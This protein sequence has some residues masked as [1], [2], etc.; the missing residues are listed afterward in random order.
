MRLLAPA[1][2]AIRSTRAPAS[3]WVANSCFAAS[4][5][6]S[7]MPSGS[8]CHFCIRLVLIKT[9]VRSFRKTHVARKAGFENEAV[10]P[11][12][13]EASNY[14]VQLHIGEARDSGSG[15]LDHPGMTKLDSFPGQR[16]KKERHSRTVRSS[17]SVW[18]PQ[19]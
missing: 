10:I 15:P 14:D 2:A 17:S 13:C 7:R 4:R 3:P 16:R 8:R 6:R 12:R 9:V 19:V 1:F 18:T 11:G 5:M